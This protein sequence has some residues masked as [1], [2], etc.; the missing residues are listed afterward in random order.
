VAPI[1][2]PRVV[3]AGLAGDS[4]KTLVSLGL[5][6]TLR[7]RG[8]V[9][10]PFKKGP[11]FIDAAWLGAAAEMA[12]RNLDTYLMP[13][14]AILASVGQLGEFSDIA[15]MEGNRGLF[16]GL[17]AAGTHST[18]QL[19]KLID[20]PVVLVIDATKSTRTVAAQVMGCQA[21]D[22]D[23]EIAGVILNRVGTSRQEAVIR[24]AVTGA[25]Q[26]P[27]LGAIPRIKGEI[28]PSRHLGLVTAMEHPRAR[29][30][31]ER[32]SASV[33]QYVDVPAV[34]EAA[35]RAPDLVAGAG[36]EEAPEIQQTVRIGVLQ[37]AAFS[38]YYPENLE[39]LMKRGA[40]LV[41]ISPLN[42]PEFPDVDA[43][44]A[45][46]GF[47]EVYAA[48][49]SANRE[50]CD[51]LAARISE[52][53]PVW[54]ECGGLMYLSRALATE[55]ATYPMVGALPIVVEQLEKPQG[56][57]YVQ[58][59]VDADNPFFEEGTELRGH[60]FHYSRL[61]AMDHRLKT[62][63]KVHRGE[64]LGGG[65]D[66][67]LVDQVL[68]AYTHLHALGVPEWADGFV[69]IAA[70]RKELRASQRAYREPAIHSG[71]RERK[72]KLRRQVEQLVRERRFDDLDELV[73]ENPRAVRHL[74]S[75]TYQLDDETREVAAR[76]IALAIRHHPGL[77][78]NVVRRLIWAM[79]EESGTNAQTAPTVLQA[80][81]GEDAEF[82]LPVLPDLIRLAADEG[83][84]RGLAKTLI[85]IKDSCPGKIGRS[86]GEALNRKVSGE[87][88]YGVGSVI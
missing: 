24:E 80:I 40:Q 29:E 11:D 60:E 62:V 34:L 30:A 81:A 36:A 14:D 55:T 2:L 1:K 45:G 6:R 4:G 54:A 67:I 85:I 42:D 88:P 41:K 13:E 37:D 48:A 33:R 47:P 5:V 43:L 69:R 71:Q 64:G 76:G 35:R 49:L 46:G 27:V 78:Q 79:N 20:A 23:L 21:M 3:V 86:L 9:V 68:A 15:V 72:G 25:C 10:A 28:L 44:Y 84:Y 87:E 19:A 22:P 77:V 8:L 12:G 75:L 83:L 82:L 31:L 53:L 66:G 16:D 39:A 51:Q 57:G 74:L 50:F 7:S 65:R 63:F 52:G 18:A 58:V 61:E 73:A 17:D 70:G 32:V 59:R 26:L 56:H 38:F